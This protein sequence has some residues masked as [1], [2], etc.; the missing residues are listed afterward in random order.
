M[1]FY[2]L[3]TTNNGQRPGSSSQI[4]SKFVNFGLQSLLAVVT[5]RGLLRMIVTALP[6]VSISLVNLRLFVLYFLFERSISHSWEY[7]SSTPCFEALHFLSHI[8]FWNVNPLSWFTSV[9]E[10]IS[11]EAKHYVHW[12]EFVKLRDDV[13]SLA[14]VSWWRCLQR[15]K[16]HQGWI[17]ATAQRE[18]NLWKKV[19]LACFN[20]MHVKKIVNFV[21]RCIFFDI[22]LA[23]IHTPLLNR[24]L[25]LETVKSTFITISFIKR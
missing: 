21:D 3:L 7:S 6:S 8:L 9:V 19:S 2:S 11:C 14:I 16:N 4:S 24:K 20:P 18:Q 10:E 22:N 12:V 5:D 17:H 1:S 15:L 23:N 13:S 25:N